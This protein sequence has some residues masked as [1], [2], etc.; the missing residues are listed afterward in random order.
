MPWPP[1]S[2]RTGRPAFVETWKPPVE[3]VP[4][5]K[6]ARLDVDIPPGPG[7]AGSRLSLPGPARLTIP[8][9]L[10]Y[11]DGGS[12]L[13]EVNEPVGQA[14]ISC[15]N[16]II[17]RLLAT[18]ATRQAWFH[19]PRPGGLGQNFAGLMHLGD[20]EESLISRRI[21]TQSDQIDARL[22]ELNQHIE[23]IIQMYLRDEYSTIVEYNA[24]A[25]STAERYH[26]LV[27]ADFPA[28][29]SDTAIKRLQS[30]VTSGPRCGVYTLIHW[31]PPPANAFRLRGG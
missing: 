8:L 4:A 31:D 30:I 29:F 25:G 18:H 3:F 22:A 16:Q 13:F 2:F 9:A 20:Y 12:L 27:I 15:L 6:F 5:T 23:K 17:L 7:A 19:D 26:F 24:Q 11:P 28:N 14:V 21:W 10:S 1:Q